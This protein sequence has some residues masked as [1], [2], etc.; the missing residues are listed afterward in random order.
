MEDTS[1]DGESVE[2]LKFD[3]SEEDK[4][5]D[6]DD[7]FGMDGSA[8]RNVYDVIKRGGKLIERGKKGVRKDISEA[9]FQPS[10]F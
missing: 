9:H 1:E 6:E 5:V 4:N 8:H 2:D 3:D 10:K 7:G